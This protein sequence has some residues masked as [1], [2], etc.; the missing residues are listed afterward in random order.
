[1][2]ILILAEASVVHSR[3]WADHFRFRGWTVRWLSFPPIPADSGAQ[4]LSISHL[5]RVF[6]IVLNVRRVRRIA[7]EFKPDIV[8]AL[9]LP[10]YGWLATL[11]GCHPLAVSAWG[12]DVL[13]A[14]HRSRW[15]RKRIE[16]V[17]RDADWLFADAEMLGVAM[18]ELGA[19]PDHITISPLGVEDSW[20]DIGR[21][22]TDTGDRPL[23]V[24]T[25]RRLEPL[26]RVDTFLHAAARL[27][28]EHSSD[29][30]FVVVGDGS[31][32]PRLIQL[33][34]S[35]GMEQIK[36]TGLLDQPQLE[37]TLAAAGLYVSCS[38]SD[39]TSVSML[40]AMAAGCVPIVTDLA[41][42][43]E[44]IQHGINGLLFPVGDDRALAEMILQ[45]ASDASWRQDVVRRN[46]E[47]IS[48]RA[49]WRDNM[50]T[51]ERAMLNLIKAH[52]SSEKGQGR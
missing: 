14:P 23:N 29:F 34:Q 41:A 49:R 20:L 17:L 27:A 31:Q 24:L 48:Q 35:L 42:N 9:F 37:S 8:S 12:S 46:L 51:V 40:E 16:S 7:A 33:A 5:R 32:R 2:K 3:R 45:A 30:E 28:K 11:V 44:W 4:R 13:I 36:F 19:D 21:S 15:H 1:M 18:R 22:R 50:A 26:Y 38:E 47:I 43:H 25:C 39:G 10:D 6:D 52:G